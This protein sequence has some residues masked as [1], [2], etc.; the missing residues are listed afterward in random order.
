M[1]VGRN[2]LHTLVFAAVL[3]SALVGVATATPIVGFSG[4]YDSS[5][6]FGGLSIGAGRATQW[7]QTIHVANATIT[8][9][10]STFIG[11]PGDA[12]AFLTTAI[13]PGT[14][15]AN[16]IAHVTV[17]LPAFSLGVLNTVTLFNG[18]DLPAAHYYLILTSAAGIWQTSDFVSWTRSGI[19]CLNPPVC[20]V[21]VPGFPNFQSFGSGGAAYAPAQVFTGFTFGFGVMHYSVDGLLDGTQPPSPP[22]PQPGAPVPEPGSLALVVTGLVAGMRKMRAWRRAER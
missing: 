18:L 3:W 5:A 11:V 15:A 12:T 17:P 2:F 16:E 6:T 21:T 10:L 20:E 14:T 13:G 19:P 4:P 9:D 22:E 8:A 1:H 7:D